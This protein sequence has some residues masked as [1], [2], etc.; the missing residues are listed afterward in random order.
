ML[1][2]TLWY[3]Q[4]QIHF[5]NTPKGQ[6]ALFNSRLHFVH[7]HR[8]IYPYILNICQQMLIIITTARLKIRLTG[9]IQAFTSF[10]REW[11]QTL[12]PLQYSIYWSYMYTHTHTP[13]SVQQDCQLKNC[14]LIHYLPCNKL[15]YCLNVNK[16]AC[17]YNLIKGSFLWYWSKS[18]LTTSL[19]FE[20]RH[21]V[22][23][24]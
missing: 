24:N 14:E 5:G 15:M 2:F 9:V 1:S 12:I 6:R 20:S 16:Y 23:R 13:H 19:R 21:I 3:W 8:H 10:T 17:C 7:G 11:M 18:E 22:G 4:F